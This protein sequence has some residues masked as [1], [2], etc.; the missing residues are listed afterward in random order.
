[1]KKG[2]CIL[3]EYEKIKRKQTNNIHKIDHVLHFHLDLL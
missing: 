3:L 2:A 1:M